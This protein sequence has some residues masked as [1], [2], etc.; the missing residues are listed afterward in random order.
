MKIFS[1]SDIQS[2]N[3]DR[4]RNEVVS[5]FKGRM[6]SR[7]TP[8]LK[9]HWIWTA[10]D[11]KEGYGMYNGPWLREFAHRLSYEMNVGSLGKDDVVCHRCDTP[12]CVNP[13]HFF[14]GS[15]SLNSLDM[16]H[17][18]RARPPFSVSNKEK[19]RISRLV[20]EARVL[21]WTAD[22][23][24][25]DKG[26][27]GF[28]RNFCKGGNCRMCKKRGQVI[29]LHMLRGTVVGQYDERDPQYLLQLLTDE[30]RK[31]VEEVVRE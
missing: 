23:I 25:N 10:A 19:L 15:R 29:G 31:C 13:S 11:N 28:G 17:K 2:P 21:R 8:A 18:G 7:P 26:C 22:L 9:G 30:E 20:V 14:R 6:W 5:T 4:V 24:S 27:S 12:P 1:W 16:H 3:F